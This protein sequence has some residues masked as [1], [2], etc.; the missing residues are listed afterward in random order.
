M[1]IKRYIIWIISNFFAINLCQ[2]VPRLE[3][4]NWLTELR[5]YISED[6]HTYQVMLITNGHQRFE[7]PKIEI[8]IQ[9]IKQCT[10]TISISCKET[11]EWNERNLIT[12]PLNFNLK[13]TT[14]F[15]LILETTTPSDHSCLS[16][17]VEFLTRFYSVHS[18]PKILI[19]HFPK[20]KNFAYRKLFRKLWNRQFLDVTILQFAEKNISQ[21][22]PGS[23]ILG[24]NQETIFVYNFNPFTGIYAKEI[25][26]SRSQLFPNK[27]RN[28]HG[29]E[30]K[31]GMTHDPP[32]SYVKRNLSGHVTQIFGPNFDLVKILSKQL[33]FKINFVASETPDGK[34]GLF[35]CNIIGSTDFYRK[36]LYN[37]I[38]FIGRYIYYFR[39][40]TKPVYTKS[41]FLDQDTYIAI[42][43]RFIPEYVPNF[44]L[45]DVTVTETEKAFY[46]LFGIIIGISII[47]IFTLIVK[48]ESRVWQP[49]NILQ[50]VLG[51]TVDN[52]PR[53]F[54]Q[55]IVFAS[56]LITQVSFSGYMYIQFTHSNL[57]NS[58][59]FEINSI[60]DLENS[61][62]VPMIHFL[63][64]PI[65]NVSSVGYLSTIR[66]KYHIF[67]GN[68]EVFDCL[69]YL[70]TYGNV[71][72]ITKQFVAESLEAQFP[73]FEVSSVFKI[74][75]E[76]LLNSWRILV[77]E[78]A[79]PYV[80]K[81]DQVILYLRENGLIHK[82]NFNSSKIE[83]NSEILNTYRPY[84]LTFSTFL[85]LIVGYLVA[86]V[87]FV[88]EVLFMQIFKRK[89]KGRNKG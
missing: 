67:P 72:C 12:L 29:Y 57:K 49:L 11:V 7:N 71:S 2:I 30:M 22:Q 43:P 60:D 39:I 70:K 87:V 84:Q 63:M 8:I 61:D 64:E 35:D 34:L 23:K 32:F 36:L 48:F 33:N 6:S 31:I 37:E 77:F 78:P 15:I 75:P 40:C 5:K 50:T 27:L 16:N 18:R 74:I 81:I 38:Q 1:L 17:P 59:D 20:K 89:L 86:C 24:K 21:H 56:I 41:R 53:K 65:V 66:N 25:F 28:M 9:K 4:P 10:L 54:A 26:S 52:E 55:R 58:T 45:F 46:T 13:K 47:W 83:E 3:F 14:L 62:L 44:N 85:T 80:Q 73:E 88:S 68:G 69:I 51:F 82:W 19:I 79:S 76:P 42:V